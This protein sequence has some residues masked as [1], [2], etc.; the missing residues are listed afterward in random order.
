M[1][2]YQVEYWIKLLSQ[3]NALP[4]TTA[5]LMKLQQLVRTNELACT[6]MPVYQEYWTKLHMYQLQKCPSTNH[7]PFIEAVV[8]SED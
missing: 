4:L 8:V 7:S 5:H 6:V 1:P 3:K 2:V